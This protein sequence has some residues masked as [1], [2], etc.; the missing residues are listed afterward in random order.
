MRS[1]KEQALPPHLSKSE[2]DKL[3]LT[4]GVYY[5][6]LLIASANDTVKYRTYVTRTVKGLK[7]F[8]TATDHA[9]WIDEAIIYQIL[10]A[11][12][13][14]KGGFDAITAKLSEIKLL[15]INTI[16]LQPVTKTENGG[17]GYDVTDYMVV[18]ERLG[19]EQQLK[20]LI[21]LSKA[22]GMRVIL[23]MVPNHTSVNHPF[24]VDAVA[25]GKN[26]HYY[27]FY[28][29]VNDNAP[30]SSFYHTDKNGFMYYFWD[31]LVNLNYNNPEVQQWMIEV[32]KYWVNKYDI[33]GYRFDAVWGVNART[34]QFS[35]R[36]Q[37]ELKAIKP[38]LLLLA[39]DKATDPAVYKNGYDAAYDWTSD[40]AWVSQWTWQTHH[41][42]KKSLTIFNLADSTKRA[43]MLH[44][45]L[46]E[47][48]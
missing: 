21:D 22:L 8:N 36:L 24:A 47:I 23:D 32:C 43:P 20:R 30:Y 16:Y 39:E 3:P 7:A 48:R 41:D 35:K 5:F 11:S 15:G 31:G 19:T 10:P 14:K 18:D 44:E 40:T 4:P 37:A 6:N 1:S 9:A 33:D 45:A 26:S 34:P 27:N 2:V 46:F 28:Q 42:G 29:R 17:Q 13:V 12:F 38:E 25:N